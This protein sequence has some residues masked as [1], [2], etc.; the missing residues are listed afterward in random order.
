MI[1]ENACNMPQDDLWFSIFGFDIANIYIVKIFI[2]VFV[3]VANYIFSKVFIFRKD[4]KSSDT[5]EKAPEEEDTAEV[6]DKTETSKAE[7]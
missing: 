1:M 5:S 4:K 3:V 7:S 6:I 2:A